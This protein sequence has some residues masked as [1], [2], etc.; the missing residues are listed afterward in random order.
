MDTFTLSL[1]L[2]KRLV[3]QA[4]KL[5]RS[6]ATLK[7]QAKHKIANTNTGAAPQDQNQNGE[8]ED[9]RGQVR[10]WVQQQCN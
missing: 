7:E 9:V 6:L 4:A 1:I 10:K 8:A 2:A 3:E 5:N